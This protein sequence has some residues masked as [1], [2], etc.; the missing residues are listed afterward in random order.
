MAT[1]S[2][3]LQAGKLIGDS[4]SGLGEGIYDL[5]KKKRDAQQE[6]INIEKAKMYGDE[7]A[8][9]TY[10][11]TEIGRLT[12]LGLSNRDVEIGDV[13]KQLTSTDPERLLEIYMTD[14]NVRKDPKLMSAVNKSIEAY[15][16]FQ[17]RKAE[18]QTKWDIIA[19]AYGPQGAYGYGQKPVAMPDVDYTPIAPLLEQKY[20]AGDEA[21]MEIPYKELGLPGD[22]TVDVSLNQPLIESI[23]GLENQTTGWLGYGFGNKKYSP[24]VIDK[25]KNIVKLK[26]KQ[27]FLD[28]IRSTNPVYAQADAYDY[29]DAAATTAVE[30]ILNGGLQKGLYEFNADGVTDKPK[31]QKVP[32][33]GPRSLLTPYMQQQQWQGGSVKGMHTS[34][35]GNP[36]AFQAKDKSIELEIQMDRAV[37]LGLNKIDP[38][39]FSKLSSMKNDPQYVKQTID[40]I[41][42]KIKKAKSSK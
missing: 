31:R 7:L 28:G 16:D 33:Q 13:T 4:L 35:I 15:I 8:K 27:D 30:G 9:T 17:S 41:E 42:D 37:T 18:V 1:D 24:E 34:Q 29:A 21:K 22:G 5:R 12:S 14:P 20:G 25:V 26:L 40:I 10:G 11:A 32:V 19:K 2:E 3:I 39:L 23:K 38:D 36:N 6:Q